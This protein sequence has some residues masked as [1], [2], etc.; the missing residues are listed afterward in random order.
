MRLGSKKCQK[1][2]LERRQINRP[3]WNV[4]QT[5][6]LFRI[7][8][9]FIVVPTRSTGHNH[10]HGILASLLAEDTDEGT[11]LASTVA[12][13]NAGGPGIV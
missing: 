11:I 6:N 13:N 8:F 10:P 7:C 12:I 2:I 5:R 1:I 9:V 4:K 3:R